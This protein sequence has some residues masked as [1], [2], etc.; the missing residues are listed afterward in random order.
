L[1]DASGGQT[2]YLKLFSSSEQPQYS[3]VL[4]P[5]REGETLE[6]QF[7][8]T[9]SVAGYGPH[10]IKLQI[11]GSELELQEKS[12]GW[13]VALISPHGNRVVPWPKGLE[14]R[15]GQWN[16]F[17]IV[18]IGDV[19]EVLLNDTPLLTLKETAEAPPVKTGVQGFEVDV[20]AISVQFQPY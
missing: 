3:K 6:I 5:L 16:K 1:K 9:Q 11:G 15:K 10:G 4:H 14:L 2:K 18:K 12:D 20:G 8:P 7:R 17:R 19:C 13:G